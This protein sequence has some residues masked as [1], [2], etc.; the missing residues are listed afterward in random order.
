MIWVRIVGNGGWDGSRFLGRVGL[1]RRRP[2][3]GFR[4]VV[5]FV[6]GARSRS[7]GDN[8]D[9]FWA[10]SLRVVQPD[11]AFLLVWLEQEIVR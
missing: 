4:A 8:W 2:D 7:G 1:V 3:P 5:E 10:E 9:A 11:E 6:P